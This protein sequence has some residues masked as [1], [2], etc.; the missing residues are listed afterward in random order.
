LPNNLSDA[1]KEQGFELL[2]DGKTTNGWK[3]AKPVNFQLRD[4]K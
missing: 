4:G 1:E 3:S 2:F